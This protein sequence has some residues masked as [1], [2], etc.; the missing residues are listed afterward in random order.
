[1]DFFLCER[2]ANWREHCLENCQQVDYS[3][4]LLA[5]ILHLDLNQFPLEVVKKICIYAQ[6]NNCLSK[7]EEEEKYRL[8]QSYMKDLQDTKLARLK[9]AYMDTD[10]EPWA[11]M[12][13]GIITFVEDDKVHD[14]FIT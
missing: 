1:L 12:D 8:F 13:G 9:A 6:W 5:R 7:E 4:R 10:G 14:A 3:A 11:A 2:F